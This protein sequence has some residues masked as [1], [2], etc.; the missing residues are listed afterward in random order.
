[1]GMLVTTVCFS[2]FSW[3]FWMQGLHPEQ[4][5][6]AVLSNC[7]TPHFLIGTS[8]AMSIGTIVHERTCYSNVSVSPFANTSH[9]PSLSSPV[10][11]LEAHNLEVFHIKPETD[12]TAQINGPSGIVSCF[13]DASQEGIKPP[14]CIYALMQYFR[15]E[16]MFSSPQLVNIFYFASGGV[17]YSS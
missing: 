15:M 13:L 4:R 1:M 12:I 7:W 17:P 9:S 8:L 6:N 10:S 14:Q 5:I 2:H 16:E 3:L 11:I